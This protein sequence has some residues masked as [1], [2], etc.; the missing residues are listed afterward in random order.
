MDYTYNKC[1][2]ITWEMSSLHA[3][4]IFKATINFNKTVIVGKI[5]Q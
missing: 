4:M 1:N 2:R 5:I 3:F